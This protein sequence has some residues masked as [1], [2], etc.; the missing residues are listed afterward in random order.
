M[1]GLNK[2]YNDAFKKHLNIPNAV[3]AYILHRILYFLHKDFY[4][5]AYTKI[6]PVGLESILEIG[7]GAGNLIKK[8]SEKS[9][10]DIIIGIDKSP[11]MCKIAYC[12]NKKHIH[13]NR[14]R[15]LNGN[16]YKL[17]NELIWFDIIYIVN[18]VKHLT[19]PTSDFKFLNALLEP[20]GELVL[21]YRFSKYASKKFLL[22]HKE[23]IKTQ[24]KES[25]FDSV[26]Y[27][28]TKRY[29]SIL[30]SYIACMKD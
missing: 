27:E 12:N 8:I 20:T 28:I 6:N 21:I 9:D 19:N 5:Y 14:V 1:L 7:F 25:C 17:R 16:L 30:V 3:G 15:I 22:N 23:V 11:V 4:K 13:K 26:K 24:L 2:G 29:G 10:P 18:P